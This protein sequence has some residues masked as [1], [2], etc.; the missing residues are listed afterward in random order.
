M[1]FDSRADDIID[2]AGFTRID[3]KTVWQSIVNTGVKHEEWTIRKEYEQDKPILHLYIEV[4]EQLESKDVE[5]LI[6]DQLSSIDKDFKNLQDM[7]GIQP[8]RVTLLPEGSFQRYYEAKQKSGA[9]L[10]HLKPPHMNT[11][12]QVIHELLYS[13]QG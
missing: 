9:D 12:D 8:L 1:V 7:L 3:E 13:N 11:S 4:K 2:I 5:R 6:C 10:S